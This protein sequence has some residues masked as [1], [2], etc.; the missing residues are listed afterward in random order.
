MTSKLPPPP[1]SSF[2]PLACLMNWDKEKGNKFKRCTFLSDTGC[3]H[4]HSLYIASAPLWEE[5]D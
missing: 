1:L 4:M 5:I 3:D 2:L